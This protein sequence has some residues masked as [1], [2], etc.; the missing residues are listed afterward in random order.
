VTVYSNTD[1]E[2]IIYLVLEYKLKSIPVVD[3]E[4]RLI[5]LVPYDA[6][7]KIFHH[8]FRED[9]V[10]ESGCIHHYIKEIED[11]TTPVS[12]LVRAKIPS[13]VLGLIGAFILNG[14]ENI[15]SSF[16][17][18]ASLIP[19][20]IYLSD[21]IGTQ[22]QTLVVRM[23]ALEPAFSVKRY[24]AREVKVGGILGIIFASLLFAAASVGWGLS[25]AGAIIGLSI[26]I[27]I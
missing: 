3:S 10:L 11:I 5:G 23:I 18:L 20:M 19:V 12:R 8:E 13:L 27:S 2:R 9:D 6:I 21:T 26:L 7:V 15:L 16:F 1:Q 17:V 24:L 25:H 4:N 14:F 22:S